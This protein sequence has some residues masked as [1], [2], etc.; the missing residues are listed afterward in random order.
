MDKVLTAAE[1]KA[2]G[3]LRHLG[4][5][6]LSVGSTF[7]AA[8]LLSAL[9]IAVA[10]LA[11]RR[12]GKRRA[13]R[14]AV[15][16]RAL[17]PR[18]LFRGAS[19]KADFGLFLFNIY[20]AGAL[21]WIVL[22]AVQVSGVFVKLLTG[23]LGPPPHITLAAAPQQAID[24]LVL[25]LAYEFA[26]WVDH[27]LSHRVPALWEFHKVHHTAETLSPLTNFRV[28]PVDTLVFANICGVM[29]G[30]ATGALQYAFGQVS[31]LS[32]SGAN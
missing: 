13:L 32:L 31:P 8:S 18:R 23:A 14:A 22:T 15:L 9:V 2:V 11:W 28:H 30:G 4:D 19:S 25:F 27:V 20:P 6:F 17:F 5:V 3:L 24:T 29:V 12:R 10:V 7:S 1:S 26:Y 21:S 16:F